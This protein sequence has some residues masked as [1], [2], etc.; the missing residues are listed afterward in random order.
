MA[1]TTIRTVVYSRWSANEWYGIKTTVGHTFSNNSR[2]PSVVVLLYGIYRF[3]LQATS[4]THTV[5]I[6]AHATIRRMNP[7][8]HVLALSDVNFYTDKYRIRRYS[9]CFS[10]T[11]GIISVQVTREIFYRSLIG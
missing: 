1:V 8:W 5:E 2:L 4:E 11:Y 9:M 3:V 6:P 7:R 10:C